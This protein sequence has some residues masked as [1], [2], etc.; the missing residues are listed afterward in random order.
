M[1]EMR[2]PVHG[3]IFRSLREQELIDTGIFQRLRRIKQLALAS[4]VYPG[5]L[6]TRFEHSI[7]VM[8]LAGKLCDQLLKDREHEE[9]ALVR[10]AALLHDIGHGPFS[11]VSE[12]VL[13]IFYD[14]EK[15]VPK[16]TEKIHEILTCS[17]ISYS[18][19]LSRLVC[20][21]D[22]D[23]IIGLLSGTWGDRILKD[24]VSGPLDADKLDYLLRD[25]Y[26]C[27]VKYGIY[28]LDRLLS[29]F[30]QLGNGDDFAVA[31]S[32]DGLHSLEQFV[33]AKYYMTTQVYRHKIRLITDAMIIR[34]L[35]LGIV[36][37]RI[38]FLA[39]LYSFDNTEEHLNEWLRWNDE[40]IISAICGSQTPDG[41][42]KRMFSDLYHRRLHKRV[43]HE[44]LT[45]FSP[46]V[47]E[48]LA[49]KDKFR[50]LQS[51]LEIAVGELLGVDAKLI[52]AHRYK[53]QSVREQSRNSEGSIMIVR[54]GGPPIAFEV[55]STL[56]RSIDEAQKD[57]YLDFYAPVTFADE[58]DKRRKLRQYGECISAIV[59]QV[60]DSGTDQRRDNCEGEGDFPDNAQPR[61]G[62]NKR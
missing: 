57:E 33:L 44:P 41:Y 2:D 24:I 61:W 19:E 1:R 40:L 22:R 50:E 12:S 38:E 17:L 62:I 53:I 11:H 14:K 32:E 31:I 28:D 39:R 45:V 48:Q 18:P 55:E 51:A 16:S 10:L 7:G 4:L 56:F 21:D 23:R 60:S 54:H 47:R 26:Y 8:H 34:A 6:H 30:E 15:V 3:F 43:F 58:K 37:D 9:R 25:S 36:E 20:D 13:E 46:L 42:A 49:D 59:E 29:T 35:T 27:G 52:I 5:A